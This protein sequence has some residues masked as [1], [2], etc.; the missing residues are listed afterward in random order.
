MWVEIPEGLNLEFT[1]TWETT[2]LGKENFD[3]YE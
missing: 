2:L 3:S 1:A